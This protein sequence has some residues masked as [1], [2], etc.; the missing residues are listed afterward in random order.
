MDE[1]DVA[2]QRI[3]FMVFGEYHNQPVLDKY[4]SMLAHALLPKF[5]AEPR[6]AG[7]ILLYLTLFNPVLVAI[8][9]NLRR[10]SGCWPIRSEYQCL[11]LMGN[12]LRSSSKTPPGCCIGCIISV[13]TPPD[14]RNI[15]RSRSTTK[16]R[17]VQHDSSYLSHQSI[18]HAAELRH[19]ELRFL[20]QQLIAIAPFDLPTAGCIVMHFKPYVRK[21]QH[22]LHRPFAAADHEF[23]HH[24]VNIIQTT[25]FGTALLPSNLDGCS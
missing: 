18:Y 12:R 3:L 15:A 16:Q 14:L 21:P 20:V 1:L 25:L 19:V 4:I 7:H 8:R 6:D 23:I 5:P 11:P 13:P 24:T 10:T 17:L 22:P 2:T 9:S